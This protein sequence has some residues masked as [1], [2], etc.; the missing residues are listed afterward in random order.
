M[1]YVDL[2][3]PR[4]GAGLAGDFRCLHQRDMPLAGAPLRVNFD[5]LPRDRGGN[6][7]YP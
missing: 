5:A 4:I 2:P 3:V 7:G 6:R 1:F